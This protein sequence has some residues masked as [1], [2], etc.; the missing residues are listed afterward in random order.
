M[1]KSLQL[2][3]TIS[4]TQVNSLTKAVTMLEQQLSETQENLQEETKAKL[5]A[6]SKVRQA[7]DA[8]TSVRDELEEEES[9]KKSLEEK[10]NALN[11]QVCIQF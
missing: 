6:L 9:N 7:E 10:V 5:A 4:L 2:P 8:L 11:F 1:K 3:Q